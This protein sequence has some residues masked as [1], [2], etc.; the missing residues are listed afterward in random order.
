MTEGEADALSSRDE[1]APR[2][3]LATACG[4]AEVVHLWLGVLAPSRYQVKT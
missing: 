3:S 4:P 1:F 2:F